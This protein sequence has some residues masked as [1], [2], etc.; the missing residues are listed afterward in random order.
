MAEKNFADALN[1]VVNGANGLRPAINSKADKNSPAL[2]GVPTAP[3][4]DNDTN[5]T[6]LATTEFCQ[7]LIQR[8]MGAT[9]ETLDTL[10][11]L[12]TA[13]NNDPNFAQTIVQALDNKLNKT[14]AANTYLGKTATAASASKVIGGTVSLTGSITGS[15]S[16]NSAG[17]VT[18]NTSGGGTTTTLYGSTGSSTTAGMTQKAITDALG[19]KADSSTVSSLQTNK[20]NTS[21]G[22]VALAWGSNG[23]GDQLWIKRISSSNNA[24]WGICFGDDT[25]GTDSGGGS[26]VSGGALAY[27]NLTVYPSD[28]FLIAYNTRAGITLT[29]D[30]KIELNATNGVFVNGTQI[31]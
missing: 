18:I 24:R 12:A 16:F 21:S 31:G 30:S 2:T 25:G 8:L 28:K 4:P 14:D 1:Q 19:N 17:N 13:I 15:G 20:F 3:T 22:K 10:V 29:A 6:Q 11:E 5:S 9:P 26:F 23:N 7:N 27:P